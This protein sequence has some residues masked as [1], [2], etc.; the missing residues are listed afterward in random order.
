MEP[1][2]SETVTLSATRLE[3]WAT[4]TAR[5]LGS[6]SATHEIVLIANSSPLCRCWIFWMVL[7]LR[8][9]L[10]FNQH[11]WFT[12]KLPSA[13]QLH[14]HHLPAKFSRAIKCTGFPRR[15]SS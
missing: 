13:I 8:D 11:T 12:N 2:G 10:N 3:L 5:N 15:S 6:C 1:L 14:D 9:G 4:L 7:L